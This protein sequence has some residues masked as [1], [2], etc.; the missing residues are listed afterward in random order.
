MKRITLLFCVVLLCLTGCRKKTEQYDSVENVFASAA[1]ELEKL[2]KNNTLKNLNLDSCILSIPDGVT[3][4]YP[5]TCTEEERLCHTNKEFAE[6]FQKQFAYY[7]PDVTLR[8][9]KII[10]DFDYKTG[11][12]DIFSHKREGETEN[13]TDCFTDV[14][15]CFFH[16]KHHFEAD[17]TSSYYLGYFGGDV[18]LSVNNTKAMNPQRMNRG[19]ATRLL[20]PEE[21]FQMDPPF[22]ME[23]WN[24]DKYPA[25]KKIYANDGKHNE[26]VYHLLEGDVSIGEALDYLEN[27]FLQSLPFSYQENQ[28]IAVDSIRVI[29]LDDT[30]YCYMFILTL[31]FEKMPFATGPAT[32]TIVSPESDYV[33]FAS[34][35]VMTGAKTVDFCA[36]PYGKDIVKDGKPYDKILHLE[37][38]VRLAGD[39]LSKEYIFELQQVSFVYQLT[40]DKSE[41]MNSYAPMTGTPSWQFDIYNPNDGKTYVVYV[42]ADNGEVRYYVRW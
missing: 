11:V 21:K 19:I 39:T 9:N 42:Q 18:F 33:F 35:A 20:T 1:S 40:K 22:F 4:L 30:S 27:D 7:F 38:A 13:E 6:S 17:E 26:E 29:P 15:N 5:I 25:P 2:Q 37:E 28:G 3:E 36:F 24:K 16:N 14:G 10:C 31:E 8:E 32:A 41:F 12:T 34:A 23:T